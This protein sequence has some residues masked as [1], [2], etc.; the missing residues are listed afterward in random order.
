MQEVVDITKSL[1]FTQ[2]QFDK[3]LAKLKNDIGKIQTD[4]KDIEHDLLGPEYIVEKLIEL[5][6]VEITFEW[7]AWKRPR[8]KLGTFARRKCK[9]L[10]QNKSGITAEIEFDV[11]IILA[12]IK[13]SVQAKKNCL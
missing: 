6:H 9:I 13:K 12:K 5:D 8:M 11:V 3:E 7:M 10:Q 1:E 4:V 2:E